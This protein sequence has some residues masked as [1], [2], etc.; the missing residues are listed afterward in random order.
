MEMKELIARINALAKKKKEG[1]P[2]T[3]EELVEKKDLYEQYLFLIRGQVE[4][5]LQNITIVDSIDE[6]E[7]PPKDVH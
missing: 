5:H 2:L 3:P 7:N 1:I 4:Q 6:V